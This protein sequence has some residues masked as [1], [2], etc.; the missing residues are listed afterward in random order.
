MTGRGHRWRG[1]SAT[2]VLWLV[3]DRILSPRRRG[4]GTR[5]AVRGRRYPRWD[6]R[7][8]DS[9][10]AH[11][12]RCDGCV[13]N[14]VGG[15]RFRRDT[16]YRIQLRR[17]THPLIHFRHVVW[18]IFAAR[19][20]RAFYSQTRCTDRSPADAFWL[21]C[22]VSGGSCNGIEPRPGEKAKSLMRETALPVYA[23][24]TSRS[25]LYK[26]APQTNLSPCLRTLS[27]VE[28][29][30]HAMPNHLPIQNPSR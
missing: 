6:A 30:A 5:I 26:D 8:A 7:T 1:R 27:V 25:V 9:H 17:R 24:S 4:R 2:P 14:G 18:A 22:R 29:A 10:L 12:Q 21:A 20:S 23:F 28:A 19:A 15:W 16:L 3:G 11:N 13:D